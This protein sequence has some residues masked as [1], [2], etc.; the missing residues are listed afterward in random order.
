MTTTGY[1]LSEK[2]MASI[3]GFEHSLN[4]SP[5]KVIYGKPVVFARQQQN[6][7]QQREARDDM[8]V[9]RIKRL[10]QEMSEGHHNE[11]ASQRDEGFTNPPA[12]NQQRAADQFNERD[13][14]AGRPKRPDRQ[15]GVGV[16]QKEFPGVPQWSHLEDLV[17]AGHEKNEP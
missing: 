1:S 16:G 11:D 9:K 15:K 12:G 3:S 8:L 5:E 13:N 2:F 7:Q 14:R 10:F 4:S 6:E 17:N